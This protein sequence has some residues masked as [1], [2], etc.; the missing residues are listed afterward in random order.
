MNGLSHLIREQSSFSRIR[1]L[2]KG[3]CGEVTLCKDSQSGSEVAVKELF[4]TTTSREQRSFLREVVIPAKLLLPGI[5]PIVGFCLPKINP[6]DGEIMPGVI[7]TEYMP[8]GNMQDLLDKQFEG[9]PNPHFGATEMSKVVFG[10]AVTM[11][12][13]HE[14]KILHRDLKPGNVFLDAKW[15]PRIADFGLSRPSSNSL[16]LTMAI[17]SPLFMAPE[18]YTEDGNPYTEKVDVYAFAMLVYQMFT[19]EIELADGKPYRSPAQLMMRVSQGQRYKRVK[20]IPDKIWALIEDCWSAKPAERPSFA[21]VVER[22]K[23]DAGICFPGTDMERYVEYQSRMLEKP[24]QGEARAGYGTVPGQR[25]LRV[26]QL[27]GKG[28]APRPAPTTNS[29]LRNAGRRFDFTRKAKQT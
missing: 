8:N 24:H 29:R 12:H 15:E 7:I 28:N 1:P 9:N 27:V 14:H 11:S 4:A 13:F 20:G 25:L 23:N 6:V 22:L 10:I 19:N 17:G 2:G 21:K 18:L 3:S 5:V 26:A 16:Q